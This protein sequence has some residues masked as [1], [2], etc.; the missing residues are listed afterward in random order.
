MYTKVLEFA[1]IYQLEMQA[2]EGKNEDFGSGLNSYEQHCPYTTELALLLKTDILKVID[3]LRTYYPDAKSELN[4]ANEYQLLVAVVLSAQCTDRM[5]NRVTPELFAKYPNFATLATAS[6]EDLEATLKSINYFKS[7]AKNLLKA[8][9]IIIE[10][11]E[12]CVPQTMD[13]LIKLPGVGRKTANVVLSELGVSPAL[14]VDTHVNRVSNRL[15]LV[16]SSNVL[17]V[18]KQL[19][20]QIE[21]DARRLFHHALILHGRY[22]CKAKTPLCGNCGLKEFC[23]HFKERG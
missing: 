6:L 3:S 17:I 20:A 23:K 7:K 21:P 2:G 8:A 13:E 16:T 9:Q 11:H 18:E 12:L 5:V 14:A 10:E 15:G 1:L 4:F 19:V 22:V